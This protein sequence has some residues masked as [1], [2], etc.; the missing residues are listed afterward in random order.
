MFDAYVQF[1]ESMI[2]AKMETV[3]DMGPSEDGEGAPVIMTLGYI[4][5]STFRDTDDL[6]LELRL[7]RFEE[8]MDRR[9]FLLSSVLLRQNPHNVHEWLK[10]VQLFEGRPRDVCT[11]LLSP[12]LSYPLTSPSPLSPSPPLPPFFTPP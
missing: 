12:P 6:D 5:L 2:N 3:A 10:R 8:L 1:E 7:A 11:S 4:V 9:P